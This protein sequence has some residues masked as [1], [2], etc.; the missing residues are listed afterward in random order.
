MGLDFTRPSTEVFHLPS[1]H[2][3]MHYIQ[4]QPD[5]LLRKVPAAD[6]RIFAASDHDPILEMQQSA[7]DRQEQRL[8]RAAMEIASAPV[9]L[10]RA[11]FRP[12]FTTIAG[13][14][15][16]NGA[17][18]DRLWHQLDSHLRDDAAREALHDSFRHA[19]AA[20]RAPAPVWPDAADD[21]EIALGLMHGVGHERALSGMLSGLAHF[22]QDGSDQI[23]NLH[24]PSGGFADE[25]ALFVEAL[26]PQLA[27]RLRFR[28]APR[29]YEA[30]RS[31]FSHRHYLYQVQDDGVDDSLQQAG[32]P[33]PG[34][35]PQS[36][37]QVAVASY[38]S[39]MRL[40]R[41]AGL[42]QVSPELRASM[43]S[44]VWIAPR[45]GDGALTGQAA[46]LEDLRQR[47][48]A[49]LRPERLTPLQ[50]IAA[51]QTADIVVIPQGAAVSETFW[52]RPDA[53]VIHLM[54]CQNLIQSAGDLLPLAHV[55]GCRFHVVFVD[56]A[57]V[58][59]PDDMPRRAAQQHSLQIGRRATARVTQMIDAELQ[60][61]QRNTL[62]A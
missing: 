2:P 37:R 60:G 6:L 40:A 17:S 3:G 59:T 21:L 57:D 53:L 58:T 7:I 12:Y 11:Q 14:A 45:G 16:L 46:L 41:Q 42:A 48:F 31:I 26:F 51:M 18:G 9:V 24:V 44:L 28:S 27:P 4:S 35:A 25:L 34:S 5:P 54:A 32:W 20:D 10:Q 23:I 56:I 39:G 52:L 47:G 1:V 62:Y 61:R 30:V 43:P 55:A 15:W 29:R 22:A 50:R 13:R 33:M 49:Q 38:D 36:R 19:R 8:P